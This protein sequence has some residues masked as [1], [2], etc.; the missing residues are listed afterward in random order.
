MAL[1]LTLG[2]VFYFGSPGYSYICQKWMAGKKETMALEFTV[3]CVCVCVCF[4][5]LRKEFTV[6]DYINF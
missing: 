3:V 2:H 4:F 1:H 6:V 5:L